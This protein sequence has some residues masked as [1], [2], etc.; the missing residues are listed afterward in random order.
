MVKIA[1]IGAGFY[2]VM[3]AVE[4]AKR[5]EVKQVIIFDKADGILNS[6]GKYNQARLHLGFHYPRS[7]ETIMQ[8]KTGYSY[9]RDRFPS[10]AKDIEKNIYI[11]RD[12]GHVTCREYLDMMDSSELRYRL[13]DSASLP[14]GY[15][16]KNEEHVAIEVD[17]GYI[18]ISILNAVLTD[19]LKQHN[20]SMR[21]NTEILD[22]DC[23]VGTVTKSCGSKEHFDAIINCSYTNPFMGF[24]RHLVPIKYELCLM[25]LISSESIKN[26]AVTIMD[27]EYVSVYPWLSD[28]HS[29]SSVSITPMIRSE[30]LA[31]LWDT[32]LNLPQKQILAAVGRLEH[33][34]KSL[35]DFD[36]VLVSHFTAPKVKI[37][38]DADDQ[39]LVK[40]FISG[41]CLTVL[42]GKL[43]AVTHFLSDLERFLEEIL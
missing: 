7:K 35:L 37:R 16:D 19:E 31:E 29:V 42:Q 41:R 28:L 13:V 12:D 17:E 36:Y 14:F 23:D 5:S 18:D 3:A 9:Y 15:K 26:H 20:I 33:H 27:G 4:A 38:D 8:S 32:Y 6:A 2:G 34:M 10:V 39:R 40:S 21:F 30:S 24:S 1:I 43:D 22:I 25:L 11:I